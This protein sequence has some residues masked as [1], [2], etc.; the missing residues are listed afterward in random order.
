MANPKTDQTICI[1]LVASKVFVSLVY[2]IHN[3]EKHVY[4]LSKTYTEGEA[5]YYR[6]DQSP[7]P[8]CEKTPINLQGTVTKVYIKYPLRKTLKTSH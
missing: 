7:S 2:I 6:I 8:F 1:Y 4:F 3:Y 5:K